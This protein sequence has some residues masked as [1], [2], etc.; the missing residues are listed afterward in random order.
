RVV[1]REDGGQSVRS[2]PDAGSDCQVPLAVAA[3]GVHLLAKFA[4]DVLE[5]LATHAHGVLRFDSVFLAGPS[6]L[7][8]SQMSTQASGQCAL[9]AACAAA[10]WESERSLRQP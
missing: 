3:V 10:A 6:L 9:K 7:R 5:V 4:G 1:G 8:F 2:A